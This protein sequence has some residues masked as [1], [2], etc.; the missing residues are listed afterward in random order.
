[1]FPIKQYLDYEI[2]IGV[3]AFI[4]FLIIKLESEH[5]HKKNRRKA[6]PKK[7]KYQD[8]IQNCWDE[9]NKKP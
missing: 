9:I 1:M 8:Y 7:K 5:Y 6:L 2:A 4:L 3:F